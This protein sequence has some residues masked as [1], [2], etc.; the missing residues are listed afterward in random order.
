[1]PRD[2]QAK[3]EAD[4]GVGGTDSHG[5]KE[6]GR[7]HRLSQER[8]SGRTS[9]RRHHWSGALKAKDEKHPKL[10]DR[11]GERLGCF[12]CCFMFS[13]EPRALAGGLG[14]AY[15]HR[16]QGFDL[17]CLPVSADGG[18]FVTRTAAPSKLQL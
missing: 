9:Q 11:D 18:P 8:G 12:K 16:R 7:D 5:F 3:A 6:L 4:G 17:L 1:M 10:G 13:L 15:V 2:P 14:G